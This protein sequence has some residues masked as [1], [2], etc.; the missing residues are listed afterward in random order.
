V[1]ADA[2]EVRNNQLA[3]EG[4]DLSLEP[5]RLD[6]V[7]CRPRE[8]PSGRCLGESAQ[9][10]EDGGQL[11][12]L[13]FGEIAGD[14]L[15]EP[16]LAL[17]AVFL[18]HRTATVCELDQGAA[19]VCGVWTAGDQAVGLELDPLWYE[20]PVFYFSNPA[21][22]HGPR[23]DVAI[24]P[25]CAGFVLPRSGLAL[26]HG[27]SLVNTPGLIDAG[28]RG[29]VKV[30]LLNT[31]LQTSVTI[32]PGDRIAQP[33]IVPIELQ[34]VGV[35]AVGGGRLLGQLSAG[36]PGSAGGGVDLV[37]DVGD[38]RDKCYDV[39]LVTEKA[40]HQ[41]EHHI[42]SGVADVDATVDSRPA[43]IYPHPAPVRGV[44]LAQFP[45]AG[46][47]KRDLAQGSAT[48]ASGTLSARGHR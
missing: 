30:L 48:L 33:V 26:R 10:R 1:A 11:L 2:V 4:H 46:V 40:L 43:G 9:Q 8:R 5:E 34:S 25:G 6:A 38:V 45:G 3:V 37:V 15:C 42:G 12:L 21:A 20:L 44:K 23:D 7:R 36:D 19:A 17:A 35:R 28:Y 13:G 24:P 41:R 47:V 29:E 32:A 31:D 22:V 16:V 14:R 39:A 27:L 18:Q